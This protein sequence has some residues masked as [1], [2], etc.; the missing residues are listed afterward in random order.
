MPRL[1]A[2][3][4]CNNFFVSCERL[5]RPDLNGKPVVVLSANDG[6][7]ISRSK[8]VKDLGVKMGEPFYKYRSYL[9]KNGTVVFSADFPFYRSVSKC[10][11]AALAR[12]TDELEVYSV[13][14]AFMNLSIATVA[15]VNCYAE[16]IKKWVHKKTQIPISIGIASTKTLAKLASDYAK[17]HSDMRGIFNFSECDDPLA[18]LGKTPAQ[19]IWGIGRRSGDF[20]C[21]HKINT[22]YDYMALDDLILKKERGISGLYTAWELRGISCVHFDK[23]PGKKSIQVARSFGSALHTEEELRDP[24]AQFIGMAASEMRRQ[25]SRAGSISVMIRSDWFKEDYTVNSAECRLPTPLSNDGELICAAFELLH[26][27]YKS[28]PAY[29][30][31]GI[32]L[33]DFSSDACTQKSLFDDMDLGEEGD[34]RKRFLKS[35]EI[36]N[37]EIGGRAVRPALYWRAKEECPKWEP[38]QSWKAERNL[39]AKNKTG[40]ISSHSFRVYGLDR[41]NLHKD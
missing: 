26:K 27:I 25:G 21:R 2:L 16:E 20:L 39:T 32:I 35:V 40:D 34:R 24:V 5:H 7:I 8:E 19:D 4:D 36:I 15:N 1:V 29:K 18:F 12:Y 10:V 23:K 17:K 41:Q 3:C 13:D 6:C 28:G 30:K 33:G 14:E 38:N 22:A 11:M 9:E 37:A 31:A